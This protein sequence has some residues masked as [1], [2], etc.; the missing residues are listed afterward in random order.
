M[1][2]IITLP[3]FVC[4]IFNIAQAQFRENR[5]VEKHHSISVSSSIQV[6]YIHSNKNE[7]VV[8]TGQQEHLSLLTTT[9]RNGKL[10][11]KYKPNTSIKTKSPSKVT[12][13]TTYTLQDVNVNSSASLSIPNPFQTD[14]FTAT[15]TSSGKLSAENIKAN[16]IKIVVNSSGKIS[17]KINTENLD[18]NATSS[19]KLTV[20]GEA[21]KVSVNM[22]SS[23][24]I[25]LS[26]TV[27]RDL[28][29]EGSSSAKLHIQTSRTLHSDLSSSAVIYYAVEPSRI[30][31]NRTSSGGKLTHK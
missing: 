27:I 24:N 18:I 13:Y 20:K 3:F 31:Q 23:A 7:I 16:S 1:K 25:D 11:I 22:S 12:V 6:E 29:C 28:L 8:E 19:G 14:S 21:N 26:H 30:L 4:F 5:K 2:K 15:V 17:Q 10:E 9:V